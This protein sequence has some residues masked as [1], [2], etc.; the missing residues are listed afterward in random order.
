LKGKDFLSNIGSLENS[1][2]KN[3][4]FGLFTTIQQGIFYQLFTYV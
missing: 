3:T 1:I 4:K 2:K